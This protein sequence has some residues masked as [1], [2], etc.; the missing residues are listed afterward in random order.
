M[1]EYL[2]RFQS[3]ADYTAHIN[4][5]ETP[6]LNVSI[7]DDSNE[8]HYMESGNSSKIAPSIDSNIIPANIK[9]D[10]TILG[11]TGTYEGEGGGFRCINKIVLN[12]EPNISTI[13][14]VSY[15]YLFD[16]ELNSAALGILYPGGDDGMAEILTKPINSNSKS[17]NQWTTVSVIDSLFQDKFCEPFYNAPNCEKIISHKLTF[18]GS[19][20]NLY[21]QITDTGL[22]NWNSDYRYD[23]S[24]EL[25]YIIVI[26]K[27]TDGTYD[28]DVFNPIFTYND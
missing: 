21:F 25:F 10:V 28:F 12:G 4:N 9:K 17:I 13:N 6:M 2:K 11:V 19:D 16:G 27:G 3:A 20:L 23:E 5:A 14:S 7:C 8:I 18:T 15:Q 26:F 24:H 22:L 1:G